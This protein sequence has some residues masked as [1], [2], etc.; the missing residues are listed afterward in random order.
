MAM[1]DDQGHSSS[2]H[3]GNDFNYFNGFSDFKD[4]NVND[5]NGDRNFNANDF[6]DGKILIKSS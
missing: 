1:I 4:S 5:F 2:N 6:N 3:R